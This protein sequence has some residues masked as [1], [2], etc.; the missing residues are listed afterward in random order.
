MY[1]CVI[2]G[3]LYSVDKEVAM[4][5]STLTLSCWGS[6]LLSGLT[7]S[8]RLFPTP[9]YGENL[10]KRYVG[11]EACK[12]CHDQEF[13]K[14]SQLSRKSR[15][16]EQL[17]KMKK[18]LT[19]QEFTRCL[20]CHTTGYGQPGG[21][22]SEESTPALKN[23]GCEVCHGPGSRHVQSAAAIDIARKVD[24]TQCGVCH[25]SDRTKAFKFKAL[26]YGGAH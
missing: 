18:G 1:W 3:F 5:I 16:Y 7:F 22:Q 23:V 13:Q 24:T 11:S 17:L 2:K 4:K 14:W 25:N 9:V 8:L 19:S 12:E 15:S 20:L 10:E 21:F 26:P 6:L